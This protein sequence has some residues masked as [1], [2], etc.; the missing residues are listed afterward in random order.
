MGRR[1]SNKLFIDGDDLAWRR[2]PNI[3]RGDCALIALLQRSMVQSGTSHGE[4][5]ATTR[6]LSDELKKKVQV[7]REMIVAKSE[8]EFAYMIVHLDSD[9]TAVETEWVNEAE[10]KAAQATG[11]FV[12]KVVK[13]RTFEQCFTSGTFT[14]FHMWK[15]VILAGGWLDYEAVCIG[16]QI[17]RL[18]GF[19]IVEGKEGNI[20]HEKYYGY[21][22]RGYSSM[23]LYGAN[24][25]ESLYQ[26]R[27]RINPSVAA[28]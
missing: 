23:I 12:E 10:V 20:L 7:L 18:E 27:F 3:G 11:R 5:D 14:T 25:F 6:E 19:A 13:E 17:L 1:K 26:V 4:L 24:H 8:G 16:A 15:R 9:P 28:Q 21:A 2:L 22:A